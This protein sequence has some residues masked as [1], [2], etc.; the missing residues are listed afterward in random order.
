MVTP[1]PTLTGRRADLPILSDRPP[2][3]LTESHPAD[4]SIWVGQSAAVGTP[5]TLAPTT[6]RPGLGLPSVL[7]EPAHL[8]WSWHLPGGQR[9]GQRIGEALGRRVMARPAPTV[10]EKQASMARMAGQN[11]EVTHVF[12]HQAAGVTRGSV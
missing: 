9:P 5:T 10:D 4:V 12:G 7:G 3:H 2:C 8:P 11:R 6:W 1:L